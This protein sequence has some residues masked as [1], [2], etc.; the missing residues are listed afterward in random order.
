MSGDTDP[1]SGAIEE[2]KTPR[3]LKWLNLGLMAIAIPCGLLAVIRPFFV[4]PRYV[5]IFR[6]V[7]VPMPELTLLVIQFYPF[8]STALLF[9]AV[10]CAIV[11]YA[12]GR[13]RMALMV[14]GAYLLACLGWM[15]LFETGLRLPMAYLQEQGGH[16]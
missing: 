13:R 2:A 10:A 4:V 12:R 9:G 15:M 8:V 3:F 11:T 5:E 16:P 1:N 6:Q 14:S 7:K